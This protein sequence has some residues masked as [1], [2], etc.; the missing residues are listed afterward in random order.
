MGTTEWVV[1]NRAS[2]ET[3]TQKPNHQ[4]LLTKRPQTTEFRHLFFHLWYSSQVCYLLIIRF[5]SFGIR[6]GSRKMKYCDNCLTLTLNELISQF[7][8]ETICAVYR[9]DMS[10]RIFTG[11]C[12]CFN[13]ELGRA[14][15]FLFHLQTS[16][17]ISFILKWNTLF[18]SNHTPIS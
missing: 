15:L 18:L 7:H 10:S 5:L 17:F 2:A 14:F 4:N 3:S 12:V 13:S 11:W 16:T 8:F 1:N 9:I 6:Q